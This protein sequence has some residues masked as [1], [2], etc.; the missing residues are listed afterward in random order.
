MTNHGRLDFAL[1]SAGY[2]GEFHALH[3][4]PEADCRKV[5]EVN[6]LGVFRSLQAEV[7]AMIQTGAGS[8]V[9]LSS[10]AGIKGVAHASP[11]CASKH[12]V[13][14]LTRSL[15]LELAQRGIRVNA[16]CPALVDTP[17]A[18]RLAEKSGVTKDA[19]AAMNPMRRSISAEEVA[20]AAVWLFSDATASVTGQAIAI[21]GG[22][23]AS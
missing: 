13:I 12:A 19:L 22:L 5:L 17:M 4:Y 3:E 20:R 2:E 8:I 6:V 1:N 11:Y 9:N 23:S 15:A 14:G 16:L 7:P 18:D 10:L 21:D